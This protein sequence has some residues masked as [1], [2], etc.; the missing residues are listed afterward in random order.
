MPR[1]FKC[2]RVDSKPP[3]CCFKPQGVPAR[4]LQQV[5]LT[6]DE[7]EALRLADFRQMYQEQAA[8]LM[9]VS[10]QTFGNIINSAH[11]KIAEALVNGSALNIEG[12]VYTITNM[13]Q[14]TC[15]DCSHEWEIP[16][17][18]GRLEK[19]PQCSS[20][21][22]HRSAGDTG[23]ARTGGRGRRNRACRRTGP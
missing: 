6:V 11:G 13:R 10:R 8:R 17:G 18:T 3:V 19:C 4:F 20:R 21:N 22:I 5:T 9:G 7:F 14:F 15:H 12:G 1:P 16:Y 2:R 23:Y